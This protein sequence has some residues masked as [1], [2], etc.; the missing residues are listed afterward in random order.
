MLR[1]LLSVRRNDSEWFLS[2]TINQYNHCVR[3]SDTVIILVIV[4][5][6]EKWR[7]FLHH[8][9]YRLKKWYGLGRVS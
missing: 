8:E 3:I 2:Q 6:R 4:S 7:G 5:R 9:P 1:L